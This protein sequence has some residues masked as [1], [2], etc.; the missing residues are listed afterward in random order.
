M[1]SV[2]ELVVLVDF[3][4]WWLRVLLSKVQ[5]SHVLQTWRLSRGYIF[6]LI[7]YERAI[8][9]VATRVSFILPLNLGHVA[10][11]V[12]LLYHL[13][14]LVLV[15]TAHQ[16]ELNRFISV[17]GL[18]LLGKGWIL[19][20]LLFF[21]RRLHLLGTWLLRKCIVLNLSKRARWD[22]LHRD[23]VFVVCEHHRVHIWA[24]GRRSYSSN[25]FIGLLL[26]VNIKCSV[27]GLFGIFCEALLQNF[28]A[29][30]IWFNVSEVIV[31]WSRS[32][33]NASFFI[34][35]NVFQVL[36]ILDNL[37]ELELFVVWTERELGKLAVAWR[38]AYI[39][40]LLKACTHYA[41]AS[42]CSSHW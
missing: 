26:T 30:F 27:I 32:Q 18:S 10:F 42:V 3:D 36:K 21:T 31:K 37:F 2:C 38:F 8:H 14:G 33:L 9:A 1:P 7:I 35:L 5:V 15:S 28:V 6:A 19:L 13:N 22:N 4:D 29:V 39:V 24:F 16:R 40:W 25:S 11:S 23:E 12:Q 17:R 41:A 34:I 20:F